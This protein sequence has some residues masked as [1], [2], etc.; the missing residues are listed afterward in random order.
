M[1]LQILIQAAG[2][3]WGG[4]SCQIVARIYGP[5]QSYLS[6]YRLERFGGQIGVIQKHVGNLMPALPFHRST[7]IDPNG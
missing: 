4:E 5:M 2:C 3:Q 1:F 7:I 6:I